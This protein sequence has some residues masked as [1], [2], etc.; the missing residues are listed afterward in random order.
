MPDMSHKVRLALEAENQ[1]RAISDY[2]AQDSQRMPTAGGWR[3]VNV[4]GLSGLSR[5]A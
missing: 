5:T 4:C 1:I 3:F 2:I